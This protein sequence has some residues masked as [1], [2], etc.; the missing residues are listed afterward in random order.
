MA[1]A[2]QEI[3]SEIASLIKKISLAKQ[4]ALNYEKNY[5]QAETASFEQAKSLESVL[6][7]D[8]FERYK[9]IIRNYVQNDTPYDSFQME[10]TQ[11]FG[12]VL[13]GRD[14]VGTIPKQGL[15]ALK[16]K[17]S[18]LAT[19][20]KSIDD[21]QGSLAI[22]N[23]TLSTL[24]KSAQEAGEITAQQAQNALTNASALQQ[25]LQSVGSF[26]KSNWVPVTMLLFFI[27]LIGLSVY[28]KQVNEKK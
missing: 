15:D 4:N 23:E 1:T 8:G 24:V 26:L 27:L 2:I 28:K 10:L 6:G 25:N 22:A 3:Q 16:E 18:L 12:G 17:Y 20:R 13:S 19:E 9:S 21:L 7:V 5:L 14:N 11:T